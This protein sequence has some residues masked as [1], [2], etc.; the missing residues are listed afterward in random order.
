MKGQ[1]V[2]MSSDDQTWNTPDWFIERLTRA[3]GPIGLDPCSN[4]WSIVNARVE[5]R[6]DRGQDGLAI[7]WGGHGL[8]YVNPPFGRALTEW[9]KKWA[10][11]GDELVALV[12]SRT[13]A[14]WWHHA[15]KY[16]DTYVNWRGRF[17]FRKRSGK[18]GNAPFP[19]TVFYYGPRREV[20][21]DEFAR[22]GL[23][24]NMKGR[25]R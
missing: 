3:L 19:S 5:I 1:R 16:S 23:A 20:F 18:R 6:F 15:A 21:L 17:S 11:E 12:P 25:I 10:A 8:V 13:D 7:P 2:L 9:S 24:V 4:E 22:S 14:S